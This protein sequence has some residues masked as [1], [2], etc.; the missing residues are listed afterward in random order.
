M[1]KYDSEDYIYATNRTFPA[2]RRGDNEIRLIMGGND[3]EGDIYA[4]GDL[5]RIY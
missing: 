4:G 3:A 2:E 5:R 1:R